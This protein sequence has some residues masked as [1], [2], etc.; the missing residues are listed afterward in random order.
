MDS[1]IVTTSRTPVAFSSVA[2]GEDEMLAQAP[3][4]EPSTAL[5]ELASTGTRITE[6]FTFIGVGN[7][8]TSS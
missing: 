2:D 6:G 1:T 7:L 4:T 8:H 3:S 5:G